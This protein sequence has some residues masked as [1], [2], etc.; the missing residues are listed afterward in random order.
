[1]QT[2]SLQGYSPTPLSE[3]GRPTDGT[4]M[5]VGRLRRMGVGLDTENGCNIFYL[6]S[7]FGTKML[8]QELRLFY[9]QF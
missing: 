7:D 6:R 4:L 8:E 3:M 1:M 2:A 9:T 5:P